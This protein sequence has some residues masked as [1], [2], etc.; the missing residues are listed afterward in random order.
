[1]KNEPQSRDV[2]ARR[3]LA[4]SGS[5]RHGSWNA[6]LL[7]LVVGE[8]ETHQVAVTEVSL[9]ALALP[10]YDGDLEAE[11][12]VPTA[13]ADLRRLIGDHDGL[14][15]A[16]P[17]HNGSVTALL[18]NALD[19]C[20][21]PVGDEVALAP[22][23]MKPVLIVGTSVSPFG[24][25]RALGHLRAILGKM[26]AMVVPEDLAVPHAPAAFAGDGFAAEATSAAAARAVRAFAG[27]LDD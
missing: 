17:E 5:E 21:R 6:R 12:G 9:R 11:E 8:L 26:G 1:M 16:C 18:K 25:V 24:A 13:A 23:Q 4:F 3:V 22:F 20:S 7:K 15:I 10:I 27:L 2:G 14:L 19:W